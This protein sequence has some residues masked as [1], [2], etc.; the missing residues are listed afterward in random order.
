MIEAEAPSVEK[1]KVEPPPM[2]YLMLKN[3]DYTPYDFVVFVIM[4]VLRYNREKAIEITDE[5]HARGKASAGLFP[6][7]IAET[8][9]TQV[10]AL[11]KENSFPLV[12]YIE[13]SA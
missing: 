9:A 7:E 6:K 10:V 4:E 13:R 2:W 5:V 8:R 11:A 12:A 1:A 3:D